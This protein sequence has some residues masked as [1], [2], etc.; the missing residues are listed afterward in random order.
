MANAK[1]AKLAARKLLE[2]PKR[3][4]CRRCIGTTTKLT[5]DMEA[6]PV[7][8]MP[9]RR[10]IFICKKGHRSNKGTTVLSHGE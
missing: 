6:Q 2:M 8:Q 5:S 1:G 9:G 10:M 3:H 4:Y 7:M